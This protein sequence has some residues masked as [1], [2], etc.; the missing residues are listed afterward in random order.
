MTNILKTIG[1]VL[2]GF[3]ATAI[4]NVA[5]FI[6]ITMA[7]VIADCVSAFRLSR[8]IHKTGCNNG[9]HGSCGKFKSSKFRKV[10]FDMCVLI[11]A[12]LLLAHFAGD[13]FLNDKEILVKTVSGVICFW[14]VWSI[15]EN[16]SSCSDKIWAKMLQKVL[17]SKVERHFDVDLEDLK[18]DN[19]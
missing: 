18:K 5:P 16:E 6:A 8:R 10:V 11:P 3:L 15:L 14:Q 9:T 12:T 7:F 4:Q 17:V 19:K 13:L 2:A 1:T